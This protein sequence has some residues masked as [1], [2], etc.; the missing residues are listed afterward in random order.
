MD[1]KSSTSITELVKIVAN[2]EIDKRI[3]DLTWEDEE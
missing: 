2:E 1:R 3:K